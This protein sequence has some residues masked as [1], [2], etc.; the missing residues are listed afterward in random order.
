[1]AD[2]PKRVLAEQASDL[3]ELQPRIGKL[4]RKQRQAARHQPPAEH[5]N[6]HARRRA[7]R[8]R[9]CNAAPQRSAAREPCAEAHGAAEHRPLRRAGDLARRLAEQQTEGIEAQQLH[10]ATDNQA[11]RQTAQHLPLSQASRSIIRRRNAKPNTRPAQQAD[12]HGDAHEHEQRG[13]S[14]R[15]R[16]GHA[17]ETVDE[18][19]N[20]TGGAAAE[21]ASGA[22]EQHSAPRFG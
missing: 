7:A 8:A 3:I 10:E 20:K 9:D 18:P 5:V 14:A 1:M 13:C 12:Q 6:Q 15:A 22:G 17:E 11:A 19:A 2:R 21:R 4:V 16:L